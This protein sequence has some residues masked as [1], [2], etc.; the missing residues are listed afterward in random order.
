MWL[1]CGS[2]GCSSPWLKDANSEANNLHRQHGVCLCGSFCSVV[3]IPCGSRSES[4]TFKR[5]E[6]SHDARQGVEASKMT[7]LVFDDEEHDF[8]TPYS[9]ACWLLNK[10]LTHDE[11]KRLFQQCRIKLETNLTKLSNEQNVNIRLAK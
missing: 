1:L 2:L 4:A 9:A 5:G 6:V 3:G 10:Q 7:T 11:A 8:L